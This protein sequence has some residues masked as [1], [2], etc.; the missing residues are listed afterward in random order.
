M[1]DRVNLTPVAIREGHAFADSV[2][3]NK[4]TLVDHELVPTAVFST[5]EIGTV[6]LPEH[7]ARERYPK[8]DV[9][10][11]R[12]KPL[13]HTLSGRDERDAHEA[14]SSMA[15]ATACVG[16]HMLGA[17]A[18]EIVQMAAIAMRL[19]ATKADFDAT[20]ALHPTRRRGAGDHAREMA[21][22]SRR[23]R[24]RQ[25]GQIRGELPMKRLEG[26]IAL[27]TGGGRRHRPGD[28]TCLFAAE[29]AQ[30]YVTDV[31]G[32][33]AEAVAGEIEALGAGAR[34]IA[35]DVRAART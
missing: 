31:D 29:G 24:R 16:C 5:P 27:V 14:R 2:F 21:A 7:I 25:S 33:A 8:L 32:E 20:M 11:A 26:R 22:A 30:V 17:D 6:G 15:T 1:T 13:K 10:K 19:K 9:Y 3:G 34:A 4:P 35:A 28:R 23:A 12:F 18:A